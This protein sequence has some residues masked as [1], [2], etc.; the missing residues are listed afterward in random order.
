MA[1]SSK[2]ETSSD[3]DKLEDFDTSDPRYRS[4]LL[5]EEYRKVRK[6]L[7]LKRAQ[8]FKDDMMQ[9]LI[10]EQDL[11]QTGDVDVL[12]KMVEITKKV[13][14]AIQSIKE[15]CAS[16][17][18]NVQ[19]SSTEIPLSSDCVSSETPRQHRLRR[20]K[21]ES[22]SP[23]VSSPK[24]PFSPTLDYER[25]KDFDE[26][27]NSLAKLFNIS[28]KEEFFKNYSQLLDALDVF[29]N[30][31]ISMDTFSEMERRFEELNAQKDEIDN[32]FKADLN[33]LTDPLETSDQN[34]KDE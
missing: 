21:K 22:P 11:L 1:S 23:H 8:R 9:K 15:I 28:D 26:M 25:I 10:Q 24:K 5:L 30:Y 34:K 18:S 20:L 7:C 32:M 12:A 17:K 19:T 13:P 6:Q 4:I 3:G 2:Q 27:I 16:S 31:K 29:K 14:Q 33:K